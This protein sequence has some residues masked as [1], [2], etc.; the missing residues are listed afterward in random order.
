MIFTKALLWK[1]D[2]MFLYQGVIYKDTIVPFNDNKFKNHNLNNEIEDDWNMP[3]LFSKTL[4]HHQK[5][6]L[7]N[8]VLALW[9][10]FPVNG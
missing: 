7:K 5:Q 6:R 4:L 1:I 3:R 9:P 8:N 10:L 2:Q